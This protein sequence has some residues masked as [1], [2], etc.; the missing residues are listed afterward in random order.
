MEKNTVGPLPRR[1]FLALGGGALATTFL[2]SGCNL[3]DENTDGGGGPS[4]EKGLEAPELAEQ[5]EAG[6]L[7]PVEERLP[8]TPLTVEPVESIGVYGG[9]WRTAFIRDAIPTA[10]AEFTIGCEFLVRFAPNTTDMTANGV[11]PNVAES[12]EYND[13]GTEYTFQ[14]R[15]GLKWS[16]GEPFT[17]D[18][19]M[20]WY[21]DIFSNADLTPAPPAW[22]TAGGEP[23]TVEKIDES[24]VVFHFAAPNGLFLPNLARIG[25]MITRAPKHYLTQFH[26]D[27][28]EDIDAAIAEAGVGTWVELFEAKGGVMATRFNNPETPTLSAWVLDAGVNED[29]TEVVGRRNPYYFKVDPEGSQ[30]PYLD[31]IHYAVVAESDTLVLNAMNGEIDFHYPNISD[32]ADKPVFAENQESGDYH[33]ISTTRAQSAFPSIQLNLAHSDP[34]KRE[35]FGNKDFRIGLSHAINRQEIIDAVFARQGEPY[36]VAPRPS[37]DFYDEEMAT[38]YTEFDLNLANQHLDSAGYTER[39]SAGMRLGPDGN[40]ISFDVEVPTTSAPMID[41]LQFVKESWAQVGIDITIK[42]E[43]HSLFIERQN[44]NQHDAAVFQAQGGLNAIIDPSGFFPFNQ[45]TRWAVPWVT[46]YNS[47]GANGEEPPEAPKRQMEL[48]DQL[49]ATAEPEAQKDLMREILTIAK[50]EF[51]TIGISLWA[52]GYGIVKNDFHNVPE[53]VVV[54]AYP[55]PVG[56]NPCQYY[57]E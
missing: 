15:E 29:V 42:S 33:F 24:T 12:F 28:A 40:P 7:P 48:Y 56:T 44:G 52:D 21:E 47:G 31:Q 43:D 49:L 34:V 17:A 54:G 18:D 26:T 38:Q 9:A 35:I 19:I 6:E 41:T 2:A 30:L 4:G 20:F 5:V 11:E 25:D 39:N 22:L 13:E 37:S 46:W 3:L 53:T 51:Y 57:K 23:V 50:E 14:L 55:N 27:H 32:P 1:H 10:W 36:Q 8:S 45:N 16:D